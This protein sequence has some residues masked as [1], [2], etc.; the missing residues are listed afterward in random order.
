MDAADRRSLRL[1]GNRE[2]RIGFLHRQR[3]QRRRL[4]RPHA[5]AVIH[6]FRHLS[7][8]DDW[9]S[10]KRRCGGAGELE[11]HCGGVGPV[12]ALECGGSTP[13]SFV[14]PNSQRSDLKKEKKESGV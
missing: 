4:P 11:Y 12:S 7:A 9:A 2:R 5:S 10:I 13:L 14:F 3:R 1:Y 8:F 6:S